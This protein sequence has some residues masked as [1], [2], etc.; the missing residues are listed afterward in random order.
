MMRQL[1]SREPEELTVSIRTRRTDRQTPEKVHELDVEKLPP[2][3]R[4]GDGGC[5]A[6]A[7]EPPDQ[8]SSSSSATYLPV[9]LWLHFLETLFHHL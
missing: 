8:N 5:I 2:R 6:G 7:L 1:E 9:T 3:R 4:G